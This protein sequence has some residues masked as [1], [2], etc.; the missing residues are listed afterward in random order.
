MAILGRDGTP[1]HDLGGGNPSPTGE[2]PPFSNPRPAETSSGARA[3]ARTR[4]EYIPGRV[5]CTS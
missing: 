3:H 1:T 5:P 4:V 2:W